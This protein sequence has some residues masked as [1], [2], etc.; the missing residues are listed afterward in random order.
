M[1]YFKENIINTEKKTFD[2]F[3]YPFLLKALGRVYTM[4]KY[5]PCKG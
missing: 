5:R 2:F 1:L 3:L 4:Y